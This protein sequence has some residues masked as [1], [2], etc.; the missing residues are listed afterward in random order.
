MWSRGV[1]RSGDVTRSKDVMR[2]KGVMRFKMTF[3]AVVLFVIPLLA[4]ASLA[5][6]DG[7]SWSCHRRPWL[8]R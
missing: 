3:G 7:V 5:V 1:T 4:M 2:F 6:Q 8:P